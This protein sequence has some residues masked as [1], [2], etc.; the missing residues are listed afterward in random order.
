M[1]YAVKRT[2]WL[3]ILVSATAIVL[4]LPR[5][6]FFEKVGQ[7]MDGT[8][9]L[10]LAITIAVFITPWEKVT[11][12]KGWGVELTLDRAQVRGALEAAGLT[13]LKNSPLWKTLS[14][15]KPEIQTAQG[16]RVLWIDDK[17]D[18]IISER[19]ILRS[20]GIDVVTAASSAKAE[21][22]LE[23]DDDFDLMISDVRRADEVDNR[24]TTYGG[25]YFIKKL[26]EK[27]KNSAVSSQ[28]PSSSAQRIARK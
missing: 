11:D 23:Q 4:A 3:K 15:L 28:Y 18:E 10:L 13:Q 27:Y 16:S 26:R 12:F 14:R 7:R 22:S 5:L 6:A 21:S 1:T 8:F 19:R 20:P 25:I 24:P 17:P 2:P 9:L